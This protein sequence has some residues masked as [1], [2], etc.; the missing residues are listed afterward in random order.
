MKYTN[1]IGMMLV[2]GGM[3][4]AASCTDFSDYNNAGTYDTGMAADK[5]LWENISTNKELSDFAEVLK[6]VGYDKVLSESHTYTVWAPVNGSFDKAEVLGMSQDRRLNQFVKNH[7]ADFSHLESDVNDTTIYMLNEKLLAFRNKLSDNLTFA[8][9]NVMKNGSVYNCPSLNGTLYKIQNPAT[10]RYN[11]YEI[12]SEMAGSA[13]DFMQYVKKY[14]HSYLDESKSVKGEIRDGLQHYDDSVMVVVNDLTE[15]SL[16]SQL[17]NEDSLYTVLIPTNDAWRNNYDK[18]RE[19]YKYISPIDYQDLNSEAVGTTKG[20][21]CPT[22]ATGRAT[23]MAATLGKTTTTLA[24]PAADAEITET[25]AYWNDSITKRFLVLDNVFTETNKKYNGKLATGER[26]VENDTLLSSTRDYLTNL[27]YLDQVTVENIELSNGHARVINDFPFSAEETYAPTLRTRNVGRVVTAT[28][29]SYENVIVQGL[30]ESFVKFD[31]NDETE[32]RYVKAALPSTSNAAPE[33]D[34]YLNNVLSTTYDIYLVVVPGWLEHAG[35]EDYVRKPYT[36]R[37]DI[38]YTD[39]DNKQIAGRFDGNTVVTETAPMSK[40]AAFQVA[41][42]KIDT[43]KLGTVTFPICYARTEA[44]P[45]IKVMSTLATFNATNKKKFEQ[46]LR[47][48]NV[49][50]RPRNENATKED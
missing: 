34:F 26:F 49:I 33:L 19:Y 3:L 36:L 45:N 1:Y 44:R 46:E 6:S 35:E 24:A 48:A 8:G 5:T 27:P 40:V 37:V 11:G 7:I 47:I 22:T 15:G 12:I 18:I 28:G 50:L 42:D 31:T 32:L 39:A 41:Q 2:A 17:S 43:L 38:N 23:I 4:A 9:E 14:E 25:T 16:R 10:F 30:P 13:S 20:G 21:T 29:S